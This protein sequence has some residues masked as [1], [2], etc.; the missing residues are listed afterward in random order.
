MVLILSIS[1]YFQMRG[2]KWIKQ[3]IG[4]IICNMYCIQIYIYTWF[5]TIIYFCMIFVGLPLEYW[6]SQKSCPFSYRNSPYA[7]WLRKKTVLAA[8]WPILVIFLFQ[9]SWCL[10]LGHVVCGF[11]IFWLNNTPVGVG[12]KEKQGF[13]VSTK[14]D[15]KT[16]K[17]C[18]SRK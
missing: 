10:L 18:M 16:I 13:I 1:H 9:S 7:G 4:C 6:V 3:R 15:W 12:L 8:F 14:S 11:K 2:Q 17:Y 5:I